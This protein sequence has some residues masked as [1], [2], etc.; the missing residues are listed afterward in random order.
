MIFLKLN[1]HATPF[2][3]LEQKTKFDKNKLHV[4]I[5]KLYFCYRFLISC[6]RYDDTLFPGKSRKFPSRKDP[7]PTGDRIQ[8]PSAWFC[9]VAA[10]SNLSA[11]DLVIFLEKL[12]TSK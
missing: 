5:F 10:V 6:R 9:F 2:Q 3:K 12:R 8:T 4:N 11:K 1:H 7:G